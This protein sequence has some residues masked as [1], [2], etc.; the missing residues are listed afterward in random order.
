MIFYDGYFYKEY[1][2]SLGN[3]GNYLTNTGSVYISR[4]GGLTWEQVH[5]YIHTYVMPI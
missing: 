3:P 4:D 2:I 5:T 1:V